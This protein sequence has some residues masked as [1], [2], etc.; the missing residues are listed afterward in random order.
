M[1]V[2]PFLFNFP[3]KGVLHKYEKKSW[4]IVKKKTQKNFNRILGIFNH[5]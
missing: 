5:C 2:Y 3:Y 1:I 4:K